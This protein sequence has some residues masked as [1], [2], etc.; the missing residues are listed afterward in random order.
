LNGI[1]NISGFT[2][3]WL[4]RLGVLLVTA[5]LSLLLLVIGALIFLDGEDYKQP[6]SWVAETFFDSELT[7]SGPLK[8]HVSGSLEVNAE[9]VQ[10]KPH[11]DSYLLAADTLKAH[12]RLKDAIFGLL[13][14]RDL[15]LTDFYLRINESES[16]DAFDWEDFTLPPVVV[17]K[18][19]FKNLMIEYQEFAPGTL[20]SFALSELIFDDVNDSGPVSL[21]ATGLF[22]GRGFSIDGTFPPLEHALDHKSPKPVVIVLEGERI[23]ARLDGT[24]TDPANGRG[25]DFNIE[26]AVPEAHEFLEIL[27]DDIPTVGE[28]QA[29]ARLQGDYTVPRLVDINAHMQRGEGVELTLTGS[30]DNILTGDGMNLHLTGHSDQPVVTS[31]LLYRKLDAI[32][33]FNFDGLLQEQNGHFYIKQ[34]DASVRSS[35]GVVLTASGEGELYG[36]EHQ[37]S[38]ADT[39][40]DLKLS[41]PSTD[42]LNLLQIDW[43]PDLGALAGKLKLIV[44]RDAI[45]LYDADINIGSTKTTVAHFQGKVGQIPLHD[46]A[47]VS[48]VDLKVDIK[49]TDVAALA[50]KFGYT[51]QQTAPGHARTRM[52]G[53]LDNISLGETTISIGNKGG[54]QINAKGKA[55]NIVVTGTDLTANAHF[56]VTAS[57]ANLSDLSGLAGTDLPALGATTMSSNLVVRGSELKFDDLAVNIGAT[58]QPTIRINGKIDTLLHKGSTVSVRFDVAVGDLAAAL[59]GKPPGYLGRM[60]G[61]ADVSDMDGSWGVEK[62]TLVSSDTSIYKIDIGGVHKDKD[63]TV[64]LKVNTAIDINDPVALG[65]ALDIDLSGFSAYH[66]KG[67]LTGTETTLSYISKDSLG[68]T[69]GTTTLSGSL[70]KGR[71]TFKGKYEIPVLYLSD[72]GF[73]PNEEDTEPVKVDLDSPGSGDIFSREPFDIDFLNTF[74]MDFDFLIDQ[75]ESHGALSIDSIN[76]R[77]HL[78]DGDLQVKPFKFLY[79]GGTMDIIFGLQAQRTPS[80]KLKVMA[81]D[82]KLGP[83]MAQV[84]DDVPINGYSNIHMDITA[85]GQSPHD[86]ASSLN[87]HISLGFENAK[88]PSKYIQFLSVD[89]LGWAVSR[90]FRKNKYADLNCVV[91]KFEAT[92]GKIKSTV[93]IADGPSLSLGG[94]IR[95]N[96]GKETMKIVLLPKEKRK[97][98]SSVSPVTIKGPMR[99][100][101]V[102]AIPTQAAVQEIGAMALVPYVYVP[103]KLLGNLWSIVDDGDEPGQGCASIEAVSEEA[104]KKLQEEAQ[105]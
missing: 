68:R 66:G 91:A 36:D 55:D 50:A 77:I 14:V 42:A 88:I 105:K 2:V 85:S 29:T 57:A 33:E 82:L 20:H 48:G 84:Q 95:L 100:P 101:S 72:F 8:V 28:L 63:K 40:I 38:A 26:L 34:L 99:D 97:L 96:L 79:E 65:K 69:S 22:E 17:E 15:A 90:T 58:D 60:Q 11:D 103:L 30:V 74:D 24:I 53:N 45:G 87:G 41:A 62:F 39:G 81:D 23:H 67:L 94:S 18:A 80:F 92:D 70:V 13:W 104:E 61:T 37:F 93:L 6:F 98:F 47:G 49:T 43:I 19:D 5:L 16:G 76:A 9:G 73:N 32:K 64:F 44:S 35:A 27:G 78:K 86:L 89:V 102:E 46:T 25:M 3:R 1:D 56:A 83:M 31:W 59:T 7:I 21:Q 52:T 54:I 75:V 71:P 12:I 51:L 4:K 10:L